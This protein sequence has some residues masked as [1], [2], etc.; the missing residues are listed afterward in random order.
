MARLE[1]QSSEIVLTRARGVVEGRVFLAQAAAS[2]DGYKRQRA[3]GVRCE[4]REDAG[5]AWSVGTRRVGSYQIARN[6]ADRGD[7]LP[8]C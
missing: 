7:G 1:S 6:E 8:R 2:T 3:G 5:E 4:A